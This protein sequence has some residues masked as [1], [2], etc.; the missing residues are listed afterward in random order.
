MGLMLH[1]SKRGN[2]GHK[3]Y[4]PDETGIGR[5]FGEGEERTILMLCDFAFDLLGRERTNSGK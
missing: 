4:R 3:Y 2:K 5:H 1:F